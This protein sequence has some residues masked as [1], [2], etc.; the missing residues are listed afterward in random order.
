M[1]HSSSFRGCVAQSALRLTSENLTVLSS[2]GNVTINISSGTRFIITA[3]GKASIAMAKAAEEQLGTRLHEGV[4]IAPNVGKISNPHLR[5]HVFYGAQHNLPDADSVTATHTALDCIQKN[6]STDSVFLFLV[7]GGGS[8][9][10]CS[11][12]GVTLEEKLS[13]IRTLTA[14]GADIRVLNAFR[15]KLSTVKGG[16]TLNYVKKGQVVTLLISDLIDNLIQFIASGPTVLQTKS[17]IE[18]SNTL[19]SLPKWKSLLPAEI[20]SKLKDSPPQSTVQPHNIIVACISNAL[21]ELKRFFILHG[22]DAQIITSTLEGN[23]AQRGKDFA[24]L[25]MSTKEDFPE[26]LKKF[27]GK[28]TAAPTTN[29]I[30]FLFGGETTVVLRGDGK[31]GRCQEMVLSCLM[32]LA[33]SGKT[34]PK[35]LFLAAGTDG[36]DGPTDAAGAYITNADVDKKIV[37]KGL[38]YLEISNSYEF[39]ST[40]NNGKNHFKPGPTGT[41]VMDIQIVLL[42]FDQ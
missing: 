29:R 18:M 25:I 3:F 12:D 21:A 36:I 37:G 33:S 5:S 7:S 32:A 4:V 31:G 9:L 24:E 6:D 11:P 23:A 19:T 15:Q 14:N 42:D 2:T 27:G 13:T 38:K 30:A 26:K 20:L 16:K 22:Y 17:M 40:Y 41:N 10:F 35:F 1:Q 28:L 34:M 39:W 8:A